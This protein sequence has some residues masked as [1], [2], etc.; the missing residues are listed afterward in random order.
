MDNQNC[1]SNSRCV[2]KTV[3][4]I[5][6][7][8]LGLIYFVFGGAGLLNLMPPPADL[9]ANLQTFMAGIM[10]SGYFFP[11]LKGTETI[12]GFLLLAG[13]APALALVILA[14]ITLNIILVHTFLTPGLQN[15]VLPIIMLILHLAAAAAFWPLYRPLF[16]R[17]PAW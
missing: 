16:R 7:Y 13:I 2:N 8:G 5:A 4:K 11:L 12:C 15:L 6:R 1:P 17:V 10:V 3:Y 14:P 9:P